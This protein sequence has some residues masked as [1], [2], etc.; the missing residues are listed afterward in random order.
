MIISGWEI[1]ENY[2]VLIKQFFGNFCSKTLVCR[3][4]VFSDVNDALLH[5]GGL[6]G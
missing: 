6:K 5:P 1:K 2:H 3:K 4:F